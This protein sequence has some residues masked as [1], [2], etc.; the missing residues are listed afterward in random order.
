M[1]VSAQTLWRDGCRPGLGASAL[2]AVPVPAPVSVSVSVSVSMSM[3]VSVPMPCVLSVPPAVQLAS[4]HPL[5]S[6]PAHQRFGYPL[7]PA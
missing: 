6:Q 7:P 4:Q 3:S 5:A 2:V 1:V